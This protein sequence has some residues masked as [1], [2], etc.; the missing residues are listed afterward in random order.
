MQNVKCK[1]QNEKC[2]SAS[3]ILTFTF[4]ITVSPS[5][6]ATP[7]AIDLAP[8]ISIFIAGVARRGARAEPGAMVCAR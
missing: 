1:S 2:G 5:T 3:D 6:R 7:H 8:E 4:F